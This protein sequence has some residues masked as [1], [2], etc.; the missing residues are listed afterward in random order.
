MAKA[1]VIRVSSYDSSDGTGHAVAAIT[2][3]SKT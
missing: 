2:F 3:V 1:E